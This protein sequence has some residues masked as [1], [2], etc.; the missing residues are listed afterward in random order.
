MKIYLVV[1]EDGEYSDWRTHVESLHWTIEDAVDHLDHS[2]VELYKNFSSW[3]VTND[4]YSSWICP[5]SVIY[6]FAH[7]HA[8]PQKYQR[9]T[10]ENCDGRVWMLDEKYRINA[11]WYI[12]EKELNGHPRNIAY[13]CNQKRTCN[14]SDRCAKNRFADNIGHTSICE[15]TTD[16]RYAVHFEHINDLYRNDLYIEL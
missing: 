6:C 11:I 14:I 15:R 9:E 4:G 2:P 16:V 12:I 8:T 10:Y 3:K 1:Y 7:R 13:K 5:E